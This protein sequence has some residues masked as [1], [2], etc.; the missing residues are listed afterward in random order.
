MTDHQKQLPRKPSSNEEKQENLRKKKELIRNNK[1]RGITLSRRKGRLVRQ[2]SC[3]SDHDEESDLEFD[4][5]KYLP[6][7]YRT[8][9]KVK[10]LIEVGCTE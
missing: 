1:A 10:R 6:P 8:S 7:L 2:L 9:K 3:V 4:L 5:T